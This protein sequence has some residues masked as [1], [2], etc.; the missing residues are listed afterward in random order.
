M[1]KVFCENMLY[2]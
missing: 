1:P 2:N